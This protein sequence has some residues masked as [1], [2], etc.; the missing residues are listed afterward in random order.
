VDEQKPLITTQ[1]DRPSGQEVSDR[2]KYNFIKDY[3]N[4]IHATRIHRPSSIK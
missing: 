3:I 1:S 2:T 4:D